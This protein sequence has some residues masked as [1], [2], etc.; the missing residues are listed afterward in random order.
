MTRQRQHD[1]YNFLMRMGAI[2]NRPDEIARCVRHGATIESPDEHG[3]TAL[4]HAANHA[5]NGAVRFLVK[6]GPTPESMQRALSLAATKQPENPENLQ[7]YIET[8]LILIEAGTDTRVLE[9]A[10]LVPAMRTAIN[11]KLAE[12][13]RQ[14]LPEPGTDSGFEFLPP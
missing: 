9:G 6:K 1:Y 4:M 5:S 7:R 14:P 13:G 3:W 2:N 12:L 8:A 11:G 10:A